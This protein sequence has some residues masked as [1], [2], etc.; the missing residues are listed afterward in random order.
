MRCLLLLFTI[1]LSFNARAQSKGDFKE[2][3]KKSHQTFI[4]AILAEDFQLVSD[5][6][7]IRHTR[8]WVWDKT[9]L[10]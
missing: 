1:F 5:I 3:V 9:R 8:R 7:H 10:C 6:R 4:D 2:M